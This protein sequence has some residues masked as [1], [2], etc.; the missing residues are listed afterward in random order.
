MSRT[1]VGWDHTLVLV[2]T[3]LTAFREGTKCLMSV[4]FWEGNL[5]MS[6]VMITSCNRQNSEPSS[7]K[8]SYETRFPLS[9]PNTLIKTNAKEGTKCY[10][11]HA[12][13]IPI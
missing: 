10:H 8:T 1:A 5:E 11:W 9:L 3:L 7:A 13:N 2:M 6:A 12:G 4:G